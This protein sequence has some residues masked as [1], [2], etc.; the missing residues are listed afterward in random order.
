MNAIELEPRVPRFHA[1]AAD[2]LERAGRTE[3][4]EASFCQALALAPEDAH[5]L[6]HFSRFL[7]KTGRDAEAMR[8]AEQAVR[9]APNNDWLLAYPGGRDVSSACGRRG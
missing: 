2:L 3:E 7:A 8:I 5:L 6:G 1:H 9:L 4:A